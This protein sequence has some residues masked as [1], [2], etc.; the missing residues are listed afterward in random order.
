MKGR[1]NRLNGF[2]LANRSVELFERCEDSFL[3]LKSFY[4]E[5]L[6]GSVSVRKGRRYHFLNRWRSLPKSS[7]I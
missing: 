2:R 4:C 6:T 7:L 3:E 1:R 5:P